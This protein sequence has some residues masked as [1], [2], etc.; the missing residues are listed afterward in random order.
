MK[1]VGILVLCLTL[2]LGFH[3]LVTAE[4]LNLGTLSP[5]TGPYAQDGTD[6][7][8]GVKTAVAV[9]GP[10][11]GFDKVEVLPGDSACDGGKATMAAN[12]LINSNVNAVVGAYCSSATEPS[13]I[14]INEAKIVQT[15]KDL[16]LAFDIGAHAGDRI[17]AFRALGQFHYDFDQPELAHAALNLGLGH[18]AEQRQRASDALAHRVL[19]V[20]RGVR[21]LKDHLH[22]LNQ[23][24]ISPRHRP[25]GVEPHK[26]HGTT[27]NRFQSN[28]SFDQS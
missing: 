22:F 21:V 9:Y 2:I 16:D 17:A 7:L 4:T 12:K 28:D 3:G 19:R 6:I 13:Q 14:P 10:V 20:E 26:L 1:K 27:G 15:D 8:Q 18:A 23:F 11:K 25:G 24:R 5:L